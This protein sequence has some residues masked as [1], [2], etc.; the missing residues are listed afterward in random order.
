MAAAPPNSSKRKTPPAREAA[1][2]TAD[3]PIFR[4]PLKPQPK[5]FVALLGVLGAWVG[6]LLTIYFV[7]VFPTR[8]RH[9]VPVTPAA[10]GPAAQTVPN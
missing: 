6:V 10:T 9:L 7:T 1:S 8:D 5:L 3:A 2:E 4:P